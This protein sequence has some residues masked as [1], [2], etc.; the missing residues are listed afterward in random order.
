MSNKYYTWFDLKNPKDIFKIISWVIWVNL[1]IPET[2]VG[3]YKLVRFKDFAFL[4]QPIVS[5]VTTDLILFSVLTS[6]GGWKLISSIYK[7]SNH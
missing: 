5:L 1:L 2:I 3:F 6:K 7:P 4:W